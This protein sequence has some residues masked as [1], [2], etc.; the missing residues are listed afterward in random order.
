M[1]CKKQVFRYSAE[2]ALQPAHRFGADEDVSTAL[3]HP[4]GSGGQLQN[5]L[6]PTKIIVGFCYKNR[7]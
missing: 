1:G 4:A 7:R 2:S 3:A 5:E 6:L